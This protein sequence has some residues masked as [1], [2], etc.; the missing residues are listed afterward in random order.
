MGAGS[1]LLLGGSRD[2]AQV[3]GFSG[4]Y[5]MPLS[6]HASPKACSFFSLLV[7]LKIY[8]Y[9]VYE[10]TVL[11]FRHQKRA[12]GLIVGGCEPPCGCQELNSGTLEEQSVLL[13][14]EPSLQPSFILSF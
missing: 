9:C 6:Y 3:I 1:L 7:F 13:T 5:L 14:D 11:V 12:P 2:Q 4:K 10:Y 8:L